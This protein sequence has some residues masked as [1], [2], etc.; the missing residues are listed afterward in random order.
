MFI[1]PRMVTWGKCIGDVRNACNISATFCTATD[2]TTRDRSLPNSQP[3]MR[4]GRAFCVPGQGVLFGSPISDCVTI[5]TT[6]PS[7]YRDELPVDALM[8]H[9]LGSGSPARP[10]GFA[11]TQLGRRG[12]GTPPKPPP[13]IHPHLPRIVASISSQR[14][15]GGTSEYFVQVTHLL[16]NYYSG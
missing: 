10:F 16:I 7:I 6:A 3:D 4:L 11:S 9:L 15:S 12:A 13:V 8:S 1:K 14:T 2:G 5:W